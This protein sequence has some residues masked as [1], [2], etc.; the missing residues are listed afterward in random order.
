MMCSHVLFFFITH[1]QVFITCASHIVLNTIS[2]DFIPAYTD[3]NIYAVC[4]IFQSFLHLKRP[5]SGKA[6]YYTLSKYPNEVI[7]KAYNLLRHYSIIVKMKVRYLQFYHV[8]SELAKMKVV[9]V[10]V[11]SRSFL[12]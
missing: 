7:N 3:P 5:L 10:P 2:L 8:L 6:V 12:L 11:V 4:F 9:I 1:P